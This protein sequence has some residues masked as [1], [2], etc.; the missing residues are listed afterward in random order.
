MAA[1]E[2]SG[3]GWPCTKRGSGRFRDAGCA[4]LHNNEVRSRLFGGLVAVFVTN[5][6]RQCPGRK[7]NGKLLCFEFENVQHF[8]TVL[9]CQQRAVTFGDLV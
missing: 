7:V 3:Y 9:K 4:L 6:S 8:F 2:G 5:Q 1:K